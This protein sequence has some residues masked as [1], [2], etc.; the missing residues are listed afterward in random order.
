MLTAVLFGAAASSALAIG[1][2]IGSAWSPPRQVTG[3]PLAFASRA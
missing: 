1:A 3:V 2:A